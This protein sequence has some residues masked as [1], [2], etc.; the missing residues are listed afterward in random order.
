MSKDQ[1]NRRIVYFLGAGASYG[2][3]AYAEVQGGG[4]LLIPTQTSFW[5]TFLRF[6]RSK[7]NRRTIESFL[8]RYFRGY[9]RAPGGRMK[10][11]ERKLNLERINVEEVFTFLSE[12][13]FSPGTSDQ[14]RLYST[15]VWGALVS[16]IGAVFSRFK[17]NAKTRSIYRALLKH[18]IRSWDT[19]VSFNYDTI[20]E[21]SLP[22]NRRWFYDGISDPKDG[23]LRILKPH[24]SVNWENGRD[25]QVNEH[26][27]R[28]VIVAP[29]HLKLTAIKSTNGK[30][31]GFLDGHEQIKAVWAEME[32]QM[33]EAKA[34][35]F[36]G[37]SFPPADLYFSSVL[38]S[39]LAKRDTDPK[40]VV[41]NPDAVEI[42]K[43]LIERF[44]LNGVSVYFDFETFIRM[45]R[46]QILR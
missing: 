30:A 20:F 5:H 41:V 42:Q 17:P 19:V 12:R 8:F 44:A 46:E 38:R 45:N 7:D 25:I 4:R 26:A 9:K 1:Q 36:I 10:S 39:V 23:G 29:T 15:D 16:E 13:I 35:V 24:G 34:L 21:H 6:S 11:S 40:I 14:L 28:S 33:S 22:K 31:R 3:G 2:A 37:Y 18:H 32:R 27:E 43:R